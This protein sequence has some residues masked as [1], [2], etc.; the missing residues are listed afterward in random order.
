MSGLP[1][2]RLIE[3]GTKQI[4]DKKTLEKLYA[5][6]NRREFVHPDPLE[7][8]YNYDDPRDREIVGLVSSSLALGKVAQILR[9]VSAIL[10]MMK[11]APYIFLK[12]ARRKK[13]MNLFPGF[14]H[15][16][17][18]GAEVASM[19]FGVKQILQRYETLQACFSEGLKSDDETVLPA[20]KFFAKELKAASGGGCRSLIPA[21]DKGSACK[22]LN[23][24]LRWMVR[25]DE[26]DPGGWDCV[27]PAKLIVPLDTHM[28]CIGRALKLTN[29]KQA[30]M[31]TALE[32]TQAF[33]KFSPTDPVKYDFALTRLGIRDDTDLT[34][35]LIACGVGWK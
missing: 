10:E 14:K 8:L 22:R 4:I 13:I 27:S 1:Q 7:F 5:K 18:V 11:P 19:L 31:N 3:M 35:F 32:I 20:L 26:V 6:Y 28:Y 23:L 29:R 2:A 24:F 17:C 34:G 25:R 9:N 21:P 30:N 33:K 16:W 15:R 12:N